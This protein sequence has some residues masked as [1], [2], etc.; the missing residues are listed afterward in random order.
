MADHL[1]NYLAPARFANLAGAFNLKIM[2]FVKGHTY[3]N[4]GR[5]R[6][7]KGHKIRLGIKHTEETK[8]K[9]SK[10]LKNKYLGEKSSQWKGDNASYTAFHSWIRRRKGAPK[11]C[12]FCK[13]TNKERE[14]CWANKDHS[15]KRNID[16]FIPLC[17]PCHK[18]Y[19][20]ENNA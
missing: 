10:A 8:R 3:L 5:T 15:Y 9:L 2:T 11:I 13:T 19:D 14:L 1:N 18:K 12:E 6:F 20:L 16:D 7:K 17:Y 4:T